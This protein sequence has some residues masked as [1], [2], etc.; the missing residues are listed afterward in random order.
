MRES[1]SLSP[2]LDVILDEFFGV[3]FKNVV[4]F[5]DQ[6]VDVFFELLSGLDDLGVGFDFFFALRL[7]SDLL[8]T[9]LFFHRIPP[10][11]ES[12]IRI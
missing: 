6:L 4:D 3:F 11:M 7:S 1:V 12:W 9:F 8:L 2:F 5:I 10:W